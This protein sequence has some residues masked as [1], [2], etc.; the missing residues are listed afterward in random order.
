[1]CM[2]YGVDLTRFLPSTNEYVI[3]ASSNGWDETI[4]HLNTT[5]SAYL[6]YYK[7]HRGKVLSI[8]VSNQDEAF[9]SSSMDDTVRLWDVRISECQGLLHLNAPRISYDP[10]GMIFAAAT[11]HGGVKL[12]DSRKFDAGPFQSWKID[13]RID[14]WKDISFSLDG[15]MLLCSS[16][17]GSFYVLDSFTGD[18][19]GI[20]HYFIR[21]SL[22]LNLGNET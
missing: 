1:M 16:E 11:R 5:Q 10:V 19:V 15:K 2:K 4:R 20:E 12:F 18:L 3:H 8:S 13:S 22:K 14:M 6:R 9:I 7:G 21:Q 17:D